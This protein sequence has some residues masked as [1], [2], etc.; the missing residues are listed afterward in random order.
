[1]P[2]YPQRTGAVPA[3]A[4]APA[5]SMIGARPVRADSPRQN[6]HDSWPMIEMA[7]R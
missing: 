2:E 3:A 6:S 7:M 1:M 5:S 4:R